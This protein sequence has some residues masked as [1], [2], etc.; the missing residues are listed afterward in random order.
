[1]VSLHQTNGTWKQYRFKSTE[2]LIQTPFCIYV[3]TDTENG[4]IWKNEP[5]REKPKLGTQCMVSGNFGRKYLWLRSVGLNKRSKLVHIVRT[6][7]IKNLHVKRYRF[8]SVSAN[9][10]HDRQL[11]DNSNI[12]LLLFTFVLIKTKQQQKQEKSEVVLFF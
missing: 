1:M 7:I 11:I 6:E 2:L 8:L 5:A 10:H 12:T 9:A 3:L 4:K